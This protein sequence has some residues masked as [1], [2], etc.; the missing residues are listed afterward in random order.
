[1]DCLSNPAEKAIEFKWLKTNELK[2]NPWN[3]NRMNPEMIGKL[4]AEIKKSGMIL[5]IVVRPTERRVESGQECPPPNQECP[6]PLEYQI[7]DGEHRWMIA[8]QLGIKS[9]PCIIVLLSESEARVKTI[10][11]NRLRG[12]DDPELLARLLRDLEI[13]L[14]AMELGARLP[15]DPVEIEQTLELLELKTEEGREKLDQEMKE[16]LS[17]RIFSVIVSEPEKAI[18]ESAIFRL[19]SQLGSTFRPGSS[20]AKICEKYLVENQK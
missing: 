10:Q 14:G 15:F 7:I 8:K 6:R 18:I 17:Q 4:S 19:Q 12:E 1:M 13:E 16:M 5:P 3:P 11:L 9:V 2:P 20:L